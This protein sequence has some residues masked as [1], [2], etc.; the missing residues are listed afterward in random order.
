M[1]AYFGF[2]CS[3]S[4]DGGRIRTLTA[5]ISPTYAKPI[6]DRQE[7]GATERELHP[8]VAETILESHFTEWGTPDCWSARG[9]HAR[10]TIEFRF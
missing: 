5:P 4:S 8:V 3:G 6:L 7:A 1:T 2:T 9:F 10:P